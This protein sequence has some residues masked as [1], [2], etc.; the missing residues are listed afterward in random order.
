MSVKSKFYQLSKDDFDTYLASIKNREE[1]RRFLGDWGR[2]YFY[3]GE[4]EIDEL[5]LKINKLQ[6]EFDQ[7]MDSF[8]EFGRGQLLI[9]FFIDEIE[10]TNLI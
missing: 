4:K 10:A 8:S 3:Y 6:W 1:T 7:L 9:S 2:E 5:I